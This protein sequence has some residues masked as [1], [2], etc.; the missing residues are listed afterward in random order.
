MLTLRRFSFSNFYSFREKQEI[1]FLV[2][3][4]AP[5]TSAYF[6]A[7]SGDRLTKV[8]G[9]FGHNASGK[10]NLLKVLSFVKYFIRDSYKSAPDSEIAFYPFIF[11][12]DKSRTSDFQLEF[13]YDEAIYRYDL[14][15]NTKMVFEEKLS[16]R[17][18]TARFSQLFRRYWDEESGKYEYRRKPGAPG[19]KIFSLTRPNASII[20]TGAQNNDELCKRIWRAFTFLY[21]NVVEFGT[22]QRDLATDLSDTTTD[23]KEYPKLFNKARNLL[24]ESDL[25][26]SSIEITKDIAVDETRGTS[27]EGREGDTHVPWGMHAPRSRESKY[28]LP[29]N[30]ESSG[31]QYLYI[32]LST[33]LLVLE[34][35]ATAVIDEFETH[36]HPQAVEMLLDLFM[37]KDSNPKNAQLIFSSHY[38]PLLRLLDKQQIVL[39]EKDEECESEAWRLDEMEGVRADDNFYAKYITGAY[40]AVPDM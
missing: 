39:V 13:E 6:Q 28:F 27:A 12:D 17:K 25:G 33:L 20:S 29:F 26:L 18:T 19:N 14:S 4:N 22:I 35:G 8:L 3:K 40:G 2:D 7:P 34:S 37:S 23:Y 5:D 10:T 16:V 36:L 30:R 9:V 21:S 24:V 11:T 32:D 31:T 15:L 1:S 38:A